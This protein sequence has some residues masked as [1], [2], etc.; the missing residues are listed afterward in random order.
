MVVVIVIQWV[1]VDILVVRLEHLL[2][3]Q[4]QVLFLVVDVTMNL[5][6]Q[7]ARLVVGLPV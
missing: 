5:I 4:L 6:I 7:S 1:G 2:L 3:A